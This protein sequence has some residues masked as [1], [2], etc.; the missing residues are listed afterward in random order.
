MNFVRFVLAAGLCALSI[1]ATAQTAVTAKAVGKK[2]YIVELADA[3]A[4][5]YAGGVQGLDAT[6][7]AKGAKVNAGAPNVRAYIRYLNGKRNQTLATVRGAK[8]P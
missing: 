4:A 5:T 1:A 2:T 3:P 6:V 7:P 8:V